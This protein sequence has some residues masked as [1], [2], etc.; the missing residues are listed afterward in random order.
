M[1]TAADPEVDA[2]VARS[3]RWPD[4]MSR[5]RTILRERGLTEEIKWRKPCYTYDG[6]NI[7]ILQ[8]MTGFLALMFFKGTLLDDP[9]DVLEDQGPNSRAARRMCFTSVDDVTQLADTVARYVDE[10]IAVEVEGRRVGPAPEPVFVDELQRRLDDDASFR[11]A[12]GELTPGRQR[13]YNLY[14]AGAKQASTRAARVE[15]YASKIL[16]GKGMR[17]R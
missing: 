15:R 10:A 17:E 9:D 14:F 16:D 11:A 5:L 12:F 1:G 3:E 6:K 8:E 13:E 2:Y 7:V 4:E